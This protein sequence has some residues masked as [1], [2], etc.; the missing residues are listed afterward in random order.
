[1]G[2]FGRGWSY[3]SVSV[4]IEYETRTHHTNQDVYERL[5]RDD[6]MQASVVLATFVWQAAMR[7]AKLPRKPLP[8]ENPRP[9]ATPAPAASRK[10]EFLPPESGSQSAVLSSQ[11][12]TEN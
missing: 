5:Q 10:R 9:A 11:L 3:E 8:K 6:L 4:G 7:D 12:S 2:P 1:M